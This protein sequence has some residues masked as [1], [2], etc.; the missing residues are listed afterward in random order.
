MFKELAEGRKKYGL[1]EYLRRR[2]KHRFNRVFF[3]SR[4]PD[5]CRA[6]ADIGLEEGATV[7]AHTA[8]SRL[9]YIEGGAETLID[10]LQEV[11]GPSGC[12]LMPTFSIGGNMS[13]FFEGGACYDVRST[14]SRVGLVPEIFRNRDGVRRS[15][16]PTN[17][18]CAWGAGADQLLADHEKSTTPFGPNTPYGRLAERDDAFVLM[19]D[20]HIHSFLHHLQERVNFPNLF[21]EDRRSATVIDYDGNR[22]QVET[23]VMRPRIPYFVAVP[24]ASADKPDWAIL[25]DFALMFPSRRDREVRKMGYKFGGYPS[26]LERRA[27]FRRSGFLASRKLGRGE[28][29][30]LRIRPFL[31]RV[32]PEFEELID[33]FKDYYDPDYIESLKLP[34]T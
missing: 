10:A 31:D 8:L 16:H 11:I 17:S 21:L 23:S 29:G 4:K 13:K 19:L 22:R 7:V 9:G 24:G 30:L 12:L 18:V 20:T 33:R 5:L 34:Y 1:R 32:Q 14:P 25:H 3:S 15:L 26:L 6:L 2:A 28:I 27:E